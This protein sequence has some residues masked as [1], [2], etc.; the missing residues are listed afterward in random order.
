MSITDSQNVKGSSPVRGNFFA[1]FFCSN[2]I[3]ADLKERY[4]HGETRLT[5]NAQ[6]N[7]IT[8]R[9]LSKFMSIF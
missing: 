8:N 9:S 2:T 4:I 7:V 6:F 3:L 5:F 1:V